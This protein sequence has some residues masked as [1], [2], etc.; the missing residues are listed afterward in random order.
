MCIRTNNIIERLNREICT[1]LVGT[2]PDGNSGPYFSLRLATP[3]GW[4]P[5][6]QQEMHE[7]EAPEG[8]FWRMSL[9]PADLI[10]SELANFFAHNS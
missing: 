4:H 5:V 7:Y 8:S 2:F 10:R 9:L 1:L 6:G 3:C